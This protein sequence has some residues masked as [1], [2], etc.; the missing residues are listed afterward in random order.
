MCSEN[1]SIE[2][3][4]TI[5]INLIQLNYFDDVINA[6]NLIDLKIR[7]MNCDYCFKMKKNNFGMFSILVLR[8]SITDN[9]NYMKL[10]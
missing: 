2:K 8:K 5:P 9:M 6:F 7:R 4:R 1:S 10:K 3:I